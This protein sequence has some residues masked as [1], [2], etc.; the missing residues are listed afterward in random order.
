MSL[1]CKLDSTGAYGF[2]KPIADIDEIKQIDY[3]SVCIYIKKNMSF[4]Q[5]ILYK[6]KLQILKK[7]KLK[8]I[9]L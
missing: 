8:E 3:E 1:N 6:N 7:N 9:K 5:Q 2:I 4:N